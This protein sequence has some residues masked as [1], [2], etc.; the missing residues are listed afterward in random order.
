MGAGDGRCLA[1]R[2]RGGGGPQPGGRAREP[3][4]PERVARHRSVVPTAAA[5]MR[6]AI[7]PGTRWPHSSPGCS[8]PSDCAGRSTTYRCSPPAPTISLTTSCCAP[9]RCSGCSPTPTTGWSRYRS[10]HVPASIQRPWE[11]VSARLDRTAPHLSYIDLITYNW[12]QLD[13]DLADPM[14]IENLELLVPSVDNQEERTFYLVQVE[15]A[16]QTAPVVAAAVRAQEAVAARRPRGADPRVRPD[17][18]HPAAGG[19]RVLH[20]DPARSLSP[21]RSSTASCGRRP[22]RRSPCRSARAFRAPAAPT[23]CCSTSWTPCSAARTTRPGSAP[24]SSTCVARSR[25]TGAEFLAALRDIS[26]TD[27]VAARRDPR[28]AGHLHRTGRVVLRVSAAS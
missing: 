25:S 17:R 18:G 7:G 16:A 19:A 26:V 24:R 8:R 9:R 13:P 5:A 10:R 22:S 15:I 2:P 28:T 3:R 20:E 6:R 23:R 27:Y 21:R 12:R 4:L 11:Q 14:R 1:H